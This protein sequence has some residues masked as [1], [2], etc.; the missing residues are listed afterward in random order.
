[1]LKNII[2][3]QF[4]SPQPFKRKDKLKEKMIN[5]LLKSCILTELEHHQDQTDPLMI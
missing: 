2:M 3:I 4:M 5:R 1:M